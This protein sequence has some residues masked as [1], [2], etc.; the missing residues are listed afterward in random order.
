MDL[1]GALANRRLERE[2]RRREAAL[3]KAA[4]ALEGRTSEPL[5]TQ[6]PS[7]VTIDE[8]ETMLLPTRRAPGPR[9]WWECEVC[10]RGF[11]GYGSFLNHRCDSDRDPSLRSLRR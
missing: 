4:E 2:W 10:G 11:Y 8:A 7:A 6:E 1:T 3:R 5:L 9:T